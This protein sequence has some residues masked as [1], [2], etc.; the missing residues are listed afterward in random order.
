MKILTA[1]FQLSKHKLFFSTELKIEMSESFPNAILSSHPTH[2][3]QA[4]LVALGMGWVSKKGKTRRNEKKSFLLALSGAFY[5]WLTG[6]TGPAGQA[7][8]EP[9]V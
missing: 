2:E 6:A 5:L 4:M 3:Q 1:F 8:N 7:D 9:R